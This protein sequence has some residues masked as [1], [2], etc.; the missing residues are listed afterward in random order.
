MNC[1]SISS[2]LLENISPEWMK[3]HFILPSLEREEKE[4]VF[5]VASAPPE[6]EEAV[7]VIHMVV[8]ASA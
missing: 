4:K 1:I 2:N 6:K 5:G 7:H 8:T 3:I